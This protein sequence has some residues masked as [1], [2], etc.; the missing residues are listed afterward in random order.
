MLEQK[1]V[2]TASDRKVG[3]DLGTELV[4]VGWRQQTR[5]KSIHGYLCLNSTSWES[6][7]LGTRLMYI[8]VVLSQLLLFRAVCPQDVDRD[9]QV[10]CM[11]SLL[12][13]R[14]EF[15]VDKVTPLYNVAP[16]D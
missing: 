7:R 4:E 5:P 9:S 1:T 16:S 15:S 13:V 11:A 3:G 14:S 2:C 8:A 10:S 6:E 12:F